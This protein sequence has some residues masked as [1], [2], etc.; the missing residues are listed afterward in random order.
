[1]VVNNAVALFPTIPL[2]AK[3]ISGC[4]TETEIKQFLN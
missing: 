3:N 2:K 1:M 4:K